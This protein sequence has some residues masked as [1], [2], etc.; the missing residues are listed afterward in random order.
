[1]ADGKVLT[2][3]FLGAHPLQAARVLESLSVADAAALLAEVPA[4]IGA[5]V[6]AAMLPPA[7]ARVVAALAEAQILALLSAA[8][9]HATV[10]ILRHI[11][12][13]SRTRL[14]AGLPT[15]A[16]LA[17]RLLLGFPEDSVGAWADPEVIALT[18]GTRAAEAL[19]RVRQAQSGG[20][21]R[22]LVVDSERRVLGD[23]SLEALLHAPEAVSLAA[24]STGPPATLPAMM[25]LAAASAVDHWESNSSLPVVDR[26]GRLIGTLRHTA[27]SRALSDRMRAPRPGGGSLAGALASGYWSVVSGLAGASLAALPRV[28][29][30]LPEHR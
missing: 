26:D 10:A 29:R 2:L 12:E 22:V 8:G 7:A 20:I 24:L 14:L 11:P 4:R 18:P 28:K 23:V 17:S 5:P 9:T 21:D 16:A 15:A 19:T 6:L 30:V 13:A 25:P 3:A 27:V 1:M